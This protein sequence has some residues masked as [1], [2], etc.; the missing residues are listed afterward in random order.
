MQVESSKSG[1]MSKTSEVSLSELLGEWCDVLLERSL[2]RHH[3]H[4]N[5][6]VV[7]PIIQGQPPK[8][9]TPEPGHVYPL[10][11]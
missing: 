8:L 4:H 5:R 2:I 6:I 3:P 9:V 11:A 1:K 10:V 7:G